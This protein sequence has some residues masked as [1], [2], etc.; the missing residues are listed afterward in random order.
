MTVEHLD[1]YHN[2]TL[3]NKT[4]L[5]YDAAI[6]SRDFCMTHTSAMDILLFSKPIYIS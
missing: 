6:V 3:V 2:I 5:F 1:D 4:V